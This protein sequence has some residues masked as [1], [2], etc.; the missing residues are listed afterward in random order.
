VLTLRTPADARAVLK[1]LERGARRV[2]VL[3]G[4][5]QGLEIVEAL[6][7]RRCRVTLLERGRQLLPAFGT[8]LSRQAEEALRAAGVDVRTGVRVRRAERRRGRVVALSLPRGESLAVDLVLVAAGV[9]PRTELLQAAGVALRQDG[10][11]AVDERCATGL[12]DVY[13]CGVCVAVPRAGSG[14]PAWLAQAAVA[15]KTAQVAGANAAGGQA[16]LAPVAGTQLVRAAGL[17]LATTGLTG[18]AAGKAAAVVR[19]HPEDGAG[20][21]RVTVHLWH[22][23]ASGRVLGAEVA[24]STDAARH[25]D[26]LAAAVAAGLTVDQLA[27]LDLAHA[28]GCARPRDAVNVAATVAAAGRAGLAPSW[29][30]DEIAAQGRRVTLVD[31][32]R[33]AEIRQGTTPG[34]VAMPVAEVLARAAELP[35]RKRVVFVSTDGRRA[36][37]AARAARAAGLTRAG[38]LSG[39]LRS[40]QAAGHPLGGAAP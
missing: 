32:R 33:P 30:A 19:V 5:P 24:A 9:R 18:R 7:G 6:R 25:A 16:R 23:E 26:L 39:G 31:V 36:Y 38:Y 10:S 4:G 22:D 3:G 21:G 14:R 34:A 8:E 20:E 12:P 40:W 35:Q 1:Q 28:V 2:A 15:D 11:V 37:L 27:S 13:A 29:S 17:T